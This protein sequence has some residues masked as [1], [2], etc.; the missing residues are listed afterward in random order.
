M[1]KVIQFLVIIILL[2]IITIIV[3]VMFNPL[4]VRDKLVNS[5]LNSYLTSNI[6]GYQPL[7]TDAPA[8][9]E[10]S[11]D[12]P[13]LNDSQEKTLYDLGVDTS[14]LPTEVSPTMQQCF[15]NSLGE[16]R[17]QELVNGASPTP[18]DIFKAKN[19]IGQ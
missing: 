10:R 3:I 2:F 13:L 7:P 16:A 1:K 11:F 15:V 9:E 14:K 17:A 19:C 6:S 4:G 18:T 5:M 8:F 12:N